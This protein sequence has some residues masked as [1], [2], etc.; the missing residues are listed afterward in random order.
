[1]ARNETMDSIKAPDL[2]NLSSK[3]S[4]NIN[5]FDRYSRAE[6]SSGK[7]RVSFDKAT[8]MQELDSILKKK[9]EEKDEVE[10]MLE[11][12]QP[13]RRPKA[14]TNVLDQGVKMKLT[15]T[16]VARRRIITVAVV[17]VVL[18]ALFALLAPPFFTP[19][20]QE[21]SCRYEDIFEDKGVTG[22]KAEIVEDLNVYNLDALSSDKSESYRICTVAFEARNMTPFTC[23]MEDYVISGG[24]DHKDNIVYSTAAPDSLE[25][26]AF[27]TKTVKVEILVNRAGLS[28]EEFDK[29]VTSLT[30][31]TKGLKKR[32]AKNAGLPCIPGFMTVSDV[33]SFDPGSVKTR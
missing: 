15:G 2:K 25:I 22:Y 1:M 6:D 7:L 14:A 23:Y 19:N 32:I 4:S 33:I 30:L 3:Q 31:T 21:S 29:A 5:T 18:V 20:D 12:F 9:H 10:Q 28:D 24:G 16:Y 13:K 11:E 27:T 26:P 17:I 8:P